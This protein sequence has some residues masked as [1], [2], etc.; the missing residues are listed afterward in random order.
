MTFE[1]SR[2][3]SVRCCHRAASLS[4]MRGRLVPHQFVKG[5]ARVLTEVDR[6]PNFEDEVC[7]IYP[8]SDIFSGL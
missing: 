8:R 1:I 4:Q 7:H 2:A 6:L 5:M 3:A